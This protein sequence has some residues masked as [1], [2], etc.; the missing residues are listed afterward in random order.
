MLGNVDSGKSTTTAVLVSKP[1]ELDDGRGS[2]RK[3]VFNYQHEVANG[4]TASIGHEIMGFMA[5]GEQYVT[6]FDHTTKKNKIWPDIV[7]NS[8]KIVHLL[9]MC[10]H[11]KYLKTTMHG[12]NSL[13]PDYAMLFIGGNMGVSRMTMEH[14]FIAITLDL[15]VFVVFTK[16]DIAPQQVLAENIKKISNALKQHC[17][18]IPIL[19]KGTQNAGQLAEKVKSGKVTPIFTIS[20]HTGE[21]VE[22][23]RGFI[24][25]LEKTERKMI[26][27][28]VK[29]HE[30]ITTQFVIDDSY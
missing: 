23:L 22:A 2:L 10:G 8:V 9:D 24:S 15:P 7:E 21:G 11:E 26:K 14:L 16:T 3:N 28:N 25:K 29:T 30:S 6:K 5:N 20:N 4:R 18:K 17:S 12:L 1:G 19:V 13:Y 27:D